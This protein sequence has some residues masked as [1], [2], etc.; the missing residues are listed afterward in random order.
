[1]MI[2][3]K[4]VFE[5]KFFERKVPEMKLLQ[6]SVSVCLMASMMLIL[7]AWPA[8]ALDDGEFEYTIQGSE[9]YLTRYIGDGGDVQIPESINGIPVTKINGNC[10]IGNETVTSISIPGTVKTIE[11]DALA[12]AHGVTK[13]T[14]AEGVTAIGDKAF[15]KMENLVEANIPAS[16]A[17]NLGGWLFSGC[18][19]L[20]KVSLPEGMPEIP[21]FTFDGCSSLEMIDI[22]DSV[23]SL[24]SQSFRGTALKEVTIPAGVTQIL[25]E[26]FSGC[27]QLE[28][29]TFAGNN[30]SVIEYFAFGGCEALKHLELPTSVRRI[31]GGAF[32]G[33]GLTGLIIPYGVTELEGNIVYQCG[34]L[35]WMTV[36][37]TVTKI[38]D[39]DFGRYTPNLIVYCP[40]G[41]T[42][43]RACKASETP[44]LIDSSA[45]SQIQVLYN[46][47]R[48]SFGNTGQNPIMENDR[49]L[50]PL[51][52]V[53][54]AMGAEVMW[55]ETTETITAV[56]DNTTIE[57]TLGDT[58]LYKNGEA[59]MTL[60][61]PAKTV[62]DRT[63]V[64]VRAVAESFGAQVG[65]VDSAQ[66]VVI[67]E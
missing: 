15:E 29:V 7:L 52:A 61:V 35:H 66:I 4:L 16:A 25:N 2:L 27:T 6:R 47:E 45:D 13:I 9:I 18:K 26:V 20:Q 34:D 63:V 44:Y 62:N 54:E 46:G 10:F 19:S 51:R 5:Y 65:W 30:V 17:G 33:S 58:T 36:P 1:M 14:I 23:T 31:G 56:R 8:A 41:S 21:M 3:I 32:W 53:F 49:T 55:D 37:S 28:N 60:D 48:V 43:E 64:P 11:D 50:V 67:Q 57:L 12:S 24:G 42:A 38:E 40:A 59:A 22:P 39:N